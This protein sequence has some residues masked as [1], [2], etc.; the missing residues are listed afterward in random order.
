MRAGSLDFVE[1]VVRE[2]RRRLEQAGKT[3]VYTQD[4]QLYRVAKGVT[5]NQ[6]QYEKR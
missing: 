5:F 4:V 2:F 3:G 1:V 6:F